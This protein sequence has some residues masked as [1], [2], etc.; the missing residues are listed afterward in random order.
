MSPCPSLSRP[1]GVSKNA[2]EAIARLQPFTDTLVTI[3][4]DRLLTLAGADAPLQT[5]FGLSDDILIK[6]IQG[7]SGMLGAPGLLDVDFSH[8]LRLIHN[9]GGTFISVGHG[10]GESRAV[11]AIEAALSHPLLEDVPIQHS[12]GMIVKFTGNLTVNEVQQAM[13]YLQSRTEVDSEIIP[14]LDV[15][16]RADDDVM[17]TLLATGIGATAIEY[18]PGKVEIPQ[19]TP[20]PQ[21]EMQGESTP[22][23]F[24]AH[25][26]DAADKGHGRP[27]SA[28]LHPT[29]L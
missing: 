14:A 27:G 21:F 25:S 19:V 12:K 28:R 10:T 26:F 15:Q 3:P 18:A 16:P 22:L 4:N 11:H 29:G 7:L 5:A 9:G 6:G 8:V 2:R 24:I 20:A 13:A 1:D 17:V 23:D